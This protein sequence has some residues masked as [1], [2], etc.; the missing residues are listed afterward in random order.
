MEYVVVPVNLCAVHSNVG[1]LWCLQI[2]ALF[3][4]FVFR[5]TLIIPLVLNG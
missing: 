3:R 2:M 5:H 4:S 1:T